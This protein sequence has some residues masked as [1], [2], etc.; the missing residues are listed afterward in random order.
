LKSSVS[1]NECQEKV[2]G[3]RLENGIEAGMEDK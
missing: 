3:A 1:F 2:K